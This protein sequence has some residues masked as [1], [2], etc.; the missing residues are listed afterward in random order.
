MSNSIKKKFF[1]SLVL[2]KFVFDFSNTRHLSLSK[3]LVSY[4]ETT[5]INLSFITLFY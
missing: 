3:K 5:I 4:D 1:Q 2:R